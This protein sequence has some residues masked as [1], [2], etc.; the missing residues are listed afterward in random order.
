MCKLH[1]TPGLGSHPLCNLLKWWMILWSRGGSIQSHIVRDKS[2]NVSQNPIYLWIWL[3]KDKWCWGSSMGIKWII[4]TFDYIVFLEGSTLFNFWVFSLAGKNSIQHSLITFWIWLW[5]T[6]LEIHGLCDKEMS[7]FKA[8][9]KK[10]IK[11]KL[12]FEKTISFYKIFIG[13]S[14][15]ELIRPLKV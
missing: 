2:L 14:L 8:L 11:T 13:E 1:N 15:L 5:G 7:V 9:L 10:N 3:I 6:T 12:G 4:Y